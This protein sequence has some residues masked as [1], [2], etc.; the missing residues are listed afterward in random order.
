MKKRR[1]RRSGGW[2]KENGERY[3]IM[4]PAVS[5]LVHRWIA[6]KVSCNF[7]RGEPCLL[8]ECDIFELKE[9]YVRFDLSPGRLPVLYVKSPL[10]CRRIEGRSA[11]IR[12]IDG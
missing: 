7:A 8:I 12:R 2:K 5:S 10:C 4:K 1:K 6:R 9:V 3:E 11:R